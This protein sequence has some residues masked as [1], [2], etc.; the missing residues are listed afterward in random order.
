MSKITEIPFIKEISEQLVDRYNNSTNYHSGDISEEDYLKYKGAINAGAGHIGLGA[1]IGSYIGSSSIPLEAGMATFGLST[2]VAA[3]VAG[4]AITGYLHSKVKNSDYLVSQKRVQEE[5]NND[6]GVRFSIK[7]FNDNSMKKNLIGGMRSASILSAFPRMENRDWLQKV[8]KWVGMG[9]KANLPYMRDNLGLGICNLIE[10]YNNKFNKNVWDGLKNNK[11]VLK[12][13]IEGYNDVYVKNV[14]GFM[15]ELFDINDDDNKNIK[16]YLK[17]EYE[18][19]FDKSK[20]NKEKCNTKA[21]YDL[22]KKSLSQGYETMLIQD[23]Q[24]AFANILQQYAKERV[25][26]SDANGVVQNQTKKLAKLTN[27]L[28]EFKSLFSKTS[29]S[30]NSIKEYD[31]FKSFLSFNTEN[32]N[33]DSIIN[34]SN[35]NILK[36]IANEPFS[37]TV[38]RINGNLSNGKDLYLL[39]LKNA[40]LFHR[41]KIINSKSKDFRIDYKNAKLKKVEIEYNG[42]GFDRAIKSFQISKENYYKN[43]YDKDKVKLKY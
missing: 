34:Y 9:M 16:S 12:A 23:N 2:I 1:F 26:V 27:N 13:E 30:N 22:N 3:G 42:A 35:I 4:V 10:K 43:K 7:D 14:H 37:K 25:R 33:K 29:S 8:N 21:L 39:T 15:S 36:D 31:V 17:N 18:N 20:L 28:D 6:F 19:N 24:I 40:T 32:V 41:D 11:E 5:L 38:Q